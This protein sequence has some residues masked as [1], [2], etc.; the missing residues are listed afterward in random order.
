MRELRRGGEDMD[1]GQGKHWTKP[2]RRDDIT[3]LRKER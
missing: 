1:E 2:S 3:Q